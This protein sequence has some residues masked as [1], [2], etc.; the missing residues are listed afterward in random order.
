ML[1]SFQEILFTLRQNKLRTLLTAFGVFWGIFM[2]MLMLGAGRGMQNGVYD[3]FGGNVMDFIIVYTNTTSVAYKGMGL[4]RSIQL[5]RDDIQAIKQQIPNVRFIA[6]ENQINNATITYEKKLGNFAVHGIPDDYFKIKETVP[7]NLGRKQNPFDMEQ[8]RKICV[9][10]TTVVEKIFGKDANPVSKN[11]RINGVVMTVVGVFY[12]KSNNGRDSERV[13]IPD[14]TYRKVFGG[15]ENVQNIWLRPLEGKDGFELEKKVVELL[16]H[17]HTVSPEDKR[18][19][20]SFN[21]AEPAK[22]VKGLFI[23]INALIWFVGLGTLAAGI[24][25]VSNIMIITVK[26]RTREIGIRK[27]LGATPVNIVTTLLLESIL[28]TGVAGYAGMVLG[29][30]LLEL[31]NFILNSLQIKMAFFQRPEINFQVAITAIILLVA[32]GALAGLIPALRAARIM[33]IE[34]MRAE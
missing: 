28:V 16:Q 30:G 10:G 4:G 14:T 9:I 24:V 17:R 7:F 13:Y 33:P 8:V 12:D 5:N 2:L 11:I 21:M 6:S 25:G 3:S 29:V 23:G 26:E 15:N 27:A 34:A 22:M 1:D 31:I 32:C 20:K 19:I 18:A